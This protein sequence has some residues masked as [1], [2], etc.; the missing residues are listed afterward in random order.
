M[1]EKEISVRHP[2]FLLLK[3]GEKQVE[4]RLYDA[5]FR[6]L[7]RGDILT[8]IDESTEEKLK[9]KIEKID[10][11]PHFAE[12]IS[13]F[14]KEILG[15]GKFSEEETLRTYNSFYTE[16]EIEK[17]GVCGVTVKKIEE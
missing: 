13:F 10:V 12:M 3:S 15:F 14:H 8:F 9:T 17:F 2:Y 11:F 4:G 16:D 1:I 7:K 5:F 6:E